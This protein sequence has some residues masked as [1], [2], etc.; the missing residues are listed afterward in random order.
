MTREPQE[1]Y[2]D[3][4]GELVQP[5]RRSFVGAVAPDT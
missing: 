3:D 1:I 5:L 4:S 2:A